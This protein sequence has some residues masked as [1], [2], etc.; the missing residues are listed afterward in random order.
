MSVQGYNRLS[1]IL[2]WATVLVILALYFTHEGRRGGAVYAFHVGFGA[3]TGVF[4]IWRIIRRTMRGMPEKS[5]QSSVL[6]L[7]SKLVIS[8]FGLAILVTVVTGYLLPWTRGSALDVFGLFAIPSPIPAIHWLHEF[9]EEAHELAANA[10]ML[11]LALHVAGAL[12]HIL[13]DK[14]DVVQRILSPLRGGK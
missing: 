14:D 10:I 8:G 7:M 13:F 3:L 1:I 5:A 12:K 2:H 11:L 6:N 4:L 9:S